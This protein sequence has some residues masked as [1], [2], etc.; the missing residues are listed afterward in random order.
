MGFKN[1]EVAMWNIAIFSTRDRDIQQECCDQQ[2]E[3]GTATH[4]HLFNLIAGFRLPMTEESKRVRPSAD[5]H[6]L[7]TNTTSKIWD[8]HDN[9]LIGMNVCSSYG[10]DVLRY[11]V[12]TSHADVRTLGGGGGGVMLC[13]SVPVMLSCR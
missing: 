6:H 4:G 1:P 3:N 13:R 2:E 11:S 7:K 10:K 5:R 9:F 8:R 12:K